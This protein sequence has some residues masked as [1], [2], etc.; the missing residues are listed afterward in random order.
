MPLSRL[1]KQPE[2][3]TAAIVSLLGISVPLM[4]LYSGK[5][6]WS[7]AICLGWGVGNLL[8]I[9]WFVW[10]VGSLQVVTKRLA[11]LKKELID[12]LKFD[13]PSEVEE[14]IKEVTVLGVQAIP[15]HHQ[16]VTD[17][18]GIIESIVM[19]G[20]DVPCEVLTTG[21]ESLI[22]LDKAAKKTDGW[23]HLSHRKIIPAIV[24]LT[25][26]GSYPLESIEWYP[27][28]D[29]LLECLD[30]ELWQNKIEFSESLKNPTN[31]SNATLWA[32]SALFQP[33]SRRA[34]SKLPPMLL[35]FAKEIAGV[36]NNH[37]SFMTERGSYLAFAFWL[38]TISNAKVLA[39]TM[40]DTHVE[41]IIPIVET[42]FIYSGQ[43]PRE[44]LDYT[45]RILDQCQIEESQRIGLEMLSK[46]KRRFETL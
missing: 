4:I 20:F 19:R 41:E 42:F 36:L 44:F 5:F 6:S 38:S 9:G 3:W 26:K 10:R 15:G 2:F 17:S 18:C 37:S 1:F 16:T 33:S 23:R 27:V 34:D 14:I 8:V 11:R 45:E 40:R 25:K 43:E 22:E 31:E 28:K 29:Y 7:T 46:L 32:I 39:P 21:I 12:A 35:E 24:R 13:V 30:V